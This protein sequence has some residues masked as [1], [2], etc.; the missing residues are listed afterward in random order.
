LQR[1][2]L[3]QEIPAG[4]Y[5][6]RAETNHNIDAFAYA[7]AFDI[8]DAVVLA[9][10]T[11]FA[12]AYVSAGAIAYVFASAFARASVVASVIVLATDRANAFVSAIATAVAN[13]NANAPPSPQKGRLT[14]FQSGRTDAGDLTGLDHPE[15]RRDELEPSP[16][17]GFNGR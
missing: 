12:V 2:V 8:D 15:L 5:P 4:L 1:V 10:D 14:Q 3:G 6:S 9:I 17:V 16:L 7:D 13:A 11:D